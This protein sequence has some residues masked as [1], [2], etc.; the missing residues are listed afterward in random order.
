M[1]KHEPPAWASHSSNLG[2]TDSHTLISTHIW[3]RNNSH[4]HQHRHIAH[5]VIHTDSDKGKYTQQQT[6]VPTWVT[7]AAQQ[8]LS[9]MHLWS[10]VSYLNTILYKY[11]KK[12]PSL[13]LL[14]AWVFDFWNAWHCHKLCHT[15]YSMDMHTNI[16]T[17]RVKGHRE[18]WHGHGDR[19]TN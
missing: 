9:K 2:T 16:P 14:L 17:Y 4:T 3:H 5:M 13:K 7:L 6:H 19:H 18:Y 8:A 1:L 12:N 11:N 15:E 10:L